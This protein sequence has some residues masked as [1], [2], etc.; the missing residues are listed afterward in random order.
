MEKRFTTTGFNPFRLDDLLLLSLP[1]ALKSPVLRVIERAL[2]LDWLA[3]GY[4]CLAETD[5]PDAF[6]AQTLQYMN[7]APTIVDGDLKSIPATGPVVVVANHPFGGIEGIIMTLILK[8]VRQDVRIMANRMLKRIPEL[9][10]TFI[11]VNP[12]GSKRAAHENL[13][14]LREAVRWLKNGGLLVVFPAGDVS[15]FHPSDLTVRDGKWDASVARLVRLSGAQVVPVHIAGC[16]SPL[17][18]ALGM[19]HP[20]LRSLMLP[21]EL[22]NKRNRRIAVR[23]GEAFANKRIQGNGN[24]DDIAKYLRLH[25][26]MLT[27]PMAEKK[28]IVEQELQIDEVPIREP[29]SAQLLAAEVNALPAPAARCW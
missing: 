12:Y 25:T 5:T 26:Y 29:V 8:Q 28:R 19:F 14:P 13:K 20:A 16:N 1:T 11:G 27:R 9:S 15:R 7:V 24:D 10:E 18:H 21:R 4:E 6:A 3:R 17:F 22:A 2:G 23:I